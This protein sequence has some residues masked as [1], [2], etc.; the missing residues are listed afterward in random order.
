[1]NFRNRFENLGAPEGLREEDFLLT[2]EQV[3]ILE[4]QIR[5]NK[6]RVD[7]VVTILD[8][9]VNIEG[10]PSHDMR[11][12]KIREQMNLLMEENNTF[13][14]NLWSYWLSSET[15]GIKY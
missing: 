11:I 2:P 5:K 4:E 1:M 15:L 7:E 3:E 9:L 14:Q 8:R 13:R 6:E 12:Q 10:Y